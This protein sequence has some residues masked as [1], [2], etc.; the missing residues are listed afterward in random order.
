MFSLI[1]TWTNGWVNNR[2]AGDL[3]RHRAHYDVT[4]MEKDRETLTQRGR[5]THICISKKANIGSDDGLSPVRRQLS[6]SIL[7]YCQWD[8]WGQILV[9]LESISWHFHPRKCISKCR[10]QNGGHFASASM[11]EPNGYLKRKYVLSSAVSTVPA[12]NSASWGARPS[13][14]KKLRNVYV[15]I[16]SKRRFDVITTYLL[17]AMFPGIARACTGVASKGRHNASNSS[18]TWLKLKYRIISFIMSIL[19][20]ENCSALFLQS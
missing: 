4:A 1:C 14:S 8:A 19:P 15:I 6:E 7:A 18:E 11:C 10:Q 20:V 3:R 5:V 17:Q 16:T 2:S 13:P 12:D 9:K